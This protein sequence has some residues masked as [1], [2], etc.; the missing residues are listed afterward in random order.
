VKA[1]ITGIGPL[2]MGKDGVMYKYV[3]FKNKE[4]SYKTHLCPSQGNYT[5]WKDFLE[6]GVVLD[7]LD[8]LKHHEDLV[9]G[10][11]YPV[12]VSRPEKQGKLN[13]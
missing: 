7:N 12:L 10:D 8:L 3:F 4:G 6:K 9:S 13:I 1:T 2:L 5:R 11:S